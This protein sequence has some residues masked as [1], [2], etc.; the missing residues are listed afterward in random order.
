MLGSIADLRSEIHDLHR[1][2]S[3]D[4]QLALFDKTATNPDAHIA[5]GDRLPARA[6]ARRV[7]RDPTYIR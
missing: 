5:R 7:D 6:G 3:G 1:H 4:L 2:L